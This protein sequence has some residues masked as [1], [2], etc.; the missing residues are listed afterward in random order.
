MSYQLAIDPN[1]SQPGAGG[2]QHGLV[3]LAPT[4]L[5]APLP[6]PQVDQ[7]PYLNTPRPQFSES[8]ISVTD[9]VGYMKRYGLLGLL[10][11]LPAAA[12]IFYLLGMGPNVYEAEAKLR[13]R[14]QD[15]NVFNF[16]EM[17]RQGVTEL[18][19]PQLINNHLTEI[20][21]RRFSDYFYDRFDPVKRDVFISEELSTLGR[22]DQLLKMVGLYTPAKPAPPVDVFAE[23]IGT[24]VRVEPQKESHILRILVRNRTPQMAADI[25]NGFAQDYMKF[26]GEQE[27]GQTQS[28]R[29]YLQTKAD[30]LKKRLEVSERELASYSKSENLMQANAAQD[31]GGDKVRQLMTAITNVEIQLAKAKSDL[32]SIRATQQ[33]GRDLLEVRL[34]ADNPDVAFNRKE[35]EAAMAERKAL[36]PLCGRRHPQMIA[37]AGRIESAK[38]ALDHAAMSVVTMAEA[39]VSNLE[40]QITDFQKQLQASRGEVLDQSGK[41]VQQK[42]LSDQVAADREMYQTIVKRL[43]QAEVTGN[44]KDS[45]ALSLSDIATAPDKPVK[46]NKPV[47]AVASLIVFGFIFIGLPVGWGLFDDHVLKLV[48]QSGSPS[49]NI[50]SVKEVPHIPTGQTRPLGTPPAALSFAPSPSLPQAQVRPPVQATAAASFLSL[51]TPN[52]APVLAR[53]PLIGQGNPEAMLGQLL[54]PEPHGAAGALSQLTTTLE[55]QA[56][57]RSGLGGVILF[58]SAEAG[59]GKTLS[60]AALAAAFCHQGRSVFLMECNAVSPTLHQWFPHAT[61][62]SSWAH[63]LESLRYGKTN[64]FLLP[65]HDLPAYATNELLDGYRSW[66]DR[67]RQQVDWIILDGGPILR[68]FADVAP[69]APL[70]TDVLI[71][72]NP[73][74][75]NPA[76]LRAA[77]S[78]MQPMMSSSAFRGMIVQGAA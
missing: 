8:V 24:A 34:V 58:T 21:S 1:Q 14:L 52:Q 4:G 28:E 69:L 32:Q 36:E 73:L 13:L 3:P 10:L 68:N 41:N 62:H 57:K 16:N 48:R 42:M 66:I 72:N 56:L 55:M 2:V 75:S 30:E 60:A 12:A 74:V 5:G 47:A 53:L 11:A 22:K 7:N 29:D 19:A 76:K 70:A 25:A 35:M 51:Q 50:P 40:R 33:A 37:L 45:G 20:K 59:E 26:F 17:G 63:D 39:E 43:N 67:A 15:T 65:A 54:K 64:L 61:H 6:L 38:G 71:V 46:P 27:S 77:M 23:S 18:S 49:A 44:F 31:V 78:L 9:L